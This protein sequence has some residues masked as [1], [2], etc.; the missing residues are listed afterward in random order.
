MTH[1]FFNPFPKYLQVSEILRKRIEREFKAGD[2][3]PT[4]NELCTQFG[5][6][7]ETIREALHLLDREG[8][9][10]RHR[11]QGTFVAKRSK[12][13]GDDRVTGLTE[14]LYK[15]KEDTEWRVLERRPVSVPSDIAALMM[16][17][18]EDIVYRIVRLQLYDKQ[19]LAYHE[20]YL[21]LEYGMSVAKV[22]LRHTPITL[23]LRQSTGIECREEHQQI[24][25]VV[26]DTT[27]ADALNVRIGAPLLLM[28]RLFVD[29]RGKA[30]VVFRTHYRADRYYYTLKLPRLR[31]AAPKRR[32]SPARKGA[33]T[34]G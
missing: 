11:G 23:E 28:T 34:A 17:A 13:A 3:I 9:V 10:T 30:V 19:P 1:Q 4:E 26:A 7:R 25:A 33:R 16:L 15:L 18:A 31:R 22:D 21:L 6:S 32:R 8:L 5:V 12:P 24:E 2:Q 29:K 14:D 27:M 20:S